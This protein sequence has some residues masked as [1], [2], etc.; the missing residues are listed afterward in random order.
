MNHHPDFLMIV[1]QFR[2]QVKELSVSTVKLKLEQHHALTFIDVREDSE[3]AKGHLPQAIH[4][5]R[6]VLER[7]IGRLNLAKDAEIILYCGG[8]FRSLLAAIN[9]Q[10]MGYSNVY[11]MDGGFSGW[12]SHGYALSQP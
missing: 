5:G 3:W 10:H 8:G 4:I 9:L 7:D 1:N 2:P 12:L 6:G 11:S